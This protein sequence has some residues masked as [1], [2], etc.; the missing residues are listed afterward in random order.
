[1]SETAEKIILKEKYK[2]IIGCVFNTSGG[3]LNHYVNHIDISI[4]P[5]CRKVVCSF[6]DKTLLNGKGLEA[7]GVAV[8]HPEDCWNEYTGV[9]VA[10]VRMRINL[11]ANMNRALTC[12]LKKKKRWIPKLGEKYYDAVFNDNNGIE[13]EEMIWTDSDFDFIQLADGNV[14]RTPRQALKNAKRSMFE[15]RKIAKEARRELLS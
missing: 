1:M 5:E 12:N 7:M 10:M 15:G 8:C 2:N 6:K 9:L 13:T 14:F 3:N 4:L 11:T